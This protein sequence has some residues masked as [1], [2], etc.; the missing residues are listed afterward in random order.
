MHANHIDKEIFRQAMRH[1]DRHA[2]VSKYT[3]VSRLIDREDDRDSH[4]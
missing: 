4:C 3:S 2:K 1:V